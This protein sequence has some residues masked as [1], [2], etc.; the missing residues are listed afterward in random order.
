MNA[1][2]PLDSLLA[3][4]NNNHLTDYD[5]LSEKYFKI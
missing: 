4:I 5:Y 3:R 2:H 1:P